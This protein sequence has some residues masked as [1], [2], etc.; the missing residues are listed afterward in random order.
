[1]NEG[2]AQGRTRFGTW[3]CAPPSSVALAA[4]FSS[5]ALAGSQDLLCAQPASPDGPPVYRR[6]FV[7]STSHTG[8]LRSWIE[9]TTK[10]LSGTEAGDEICQVRAEAAGLATGGNPQFVAW[11][12]DTAN[13]AYCRVQGLAGT[14]AGGCGGGELPGAGPWV[15]T[16][17]L[18]WGSEID[19]LTSAAPEGGPRV[20]IDLDETGAPQLSQ[21]YV[22][23][24]HDS[25]VLGPTNCV[26]WESASGSEFWDGFVT[27]A[28]DGWSIGAVVDCAREDLH[29]LCLER[30]TGATPP[31]PSAPGALVFVTSTT[32]SAV[33]GGC[34]AAVSDMGVTAGDNLCKERAQAG[35]LPDPT[36]FIAWLS[37]TA[38]GAGPRLTGPGPWKRV[39]GYKVADDAADWLDGHLDAP[40]FLDE[41]GDEVST[42]EVWTGT[43]SNGSS[44]AAN[45]HCNDWNF[46]SSSKSTTAGWLAR[47]HSFWTSAALRGCNQPKHLYCFSNRV[48]IF[49][50]GF[51]PTDP[52]W[53]SGLP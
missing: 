48:V 7:T 26:D 37:D 34:T 28:I 30:G 43:E 31:P 5:F 38:N 29:L 9:V 51:E 40:N 33:L 19:T 11:I 50:N 14:K 52:D 23:G 17:G 13:D 44:T 1:M 4:L 32:C 18:F 39:D 25:G 46:G 3:R 8:D 27:N 41:F 6:V 47:T 49:W 20:Q 2:R 15:R 12:S 35:H 16:D 53:S 24:T 42:I 10:G 45:D 22:T 21:Y 36:G